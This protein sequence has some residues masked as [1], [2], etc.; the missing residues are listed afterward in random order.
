MSLIST[1]AKGLVVGSLAGLSLWAGSRFLQPTRILTPTTEYEVFRQRRSQVKKM[2]SLVDDRGRQCVLPPLGT[3]VT[4][5]K[6]GVTV[7]DVPVYIRLTTPADAR[8]VTPF[9]IGSCFKSRVEFAKVEQIVGQDGTEYQEAF[10][11]VYGRMA[12]RLGEVARPD[13]FD[14]DP[15]EQCGSGIHVHAHRDHCD[16]WWASLRSKI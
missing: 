4:V 6:A 2:I 10:S 3:E 15:N 9:D 11:F 14:P 13:G 7:G 8:R 12:Y 1:L 16:R 5:W